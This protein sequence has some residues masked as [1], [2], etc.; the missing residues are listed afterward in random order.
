MEHDNIWLVYASKVGDWSCGKE[1]KKH[2]RPHWG[3]KDY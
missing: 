3:R 1:K 2:V